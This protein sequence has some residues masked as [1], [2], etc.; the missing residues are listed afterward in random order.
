MPDDRDR[1]DDVIERAERIRRLLDGRSLRD[2]L[3]DEVMQDSLCFNFVVIGE[4]LAG[5]S[6]PL[7]HAFPDMPWSEIKAFRMCS[8]T[9]TS[10]STFLECLPSPAIS[11]RR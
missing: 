7:Q 6:L 5:V 11:C 3:I 9:A 4:A 8:S 2:L 10:A 1:L